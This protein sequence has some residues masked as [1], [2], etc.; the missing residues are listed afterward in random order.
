MKSRQIGVLKIKSKTTNFLMNYY[1]KKRLNLLIVFGTIILTIFPTHIANPDGSGNYPPPPSGNWLINTDTSVSNENLNIYGS[2]VIEGTGS[3]FLDNVLLNLTGDI[4][5]EAGAS[6]K[7]LNSKIIH[8]TPASF[9]IFVTQATNFTMIKSNLSLSRL[10]ISKTDSLMILENNITCM[11]S[12]YGAIYL[13]ECNSSIISKNYIYSSFSRGIYLTSCNHH[14]ISENNVTSL[15][16]TSCLYVRKGSSGEIWNNRIFSS[17]TGIYIWES[18]NWTINGNNITAQGNDG[19]YAEDAA[20]FIIANNNISTQNRY[21]LYF[22]DCYGYTLFTNYIISHTNDGI[23]DIRGYS[24][25]C[26]YNNITAQDLGISLTDSFNANISYN[27]ITASD[28]GIY[29]IKTDYSIIEY[30]NITSEEYAVFLEKSCSNVINNNY[31]NASNAGG[32]GI[33]LIDGCS[34]NIITENKIYAYERGVALYTYS[35]DSSCSSNLIFKNTISAKNYGISLYSYYTDSRSIKDNSFILNSIEAYTGTSFFL[36]KN[37][38]NN[39]FVANNISSKDDG[40][41]CLFSDSN[42]FTGNYIADNFRAMSFDSAS[43]DNLIFCNMF[44]NNTNHASSPNSNSWNNATRGNYWD[45]Y[46]G[47][48]NNGDGIGDTALP[49]EG[50]YYDYFPLMN[51]PY[52][53]IKPITSIQSDHTFNEGESTVEWL[54]WTATDANLGFL[55]FIVNNNHMSTIFQGLWNGSSFGFNLNDFNVG[56]YEITVYVLDIFGNWVVDTCNIGVFPAII[57][58]TTTTL[59][60]GTTFTTTKPSTT[61][62][63]S[64]SPSSGTSS[65]PFYSATPTG[66]SKDGGDVSW[67]I[68]ID[69]GDAGSINFDVN[70]EATLNHDPMYNIDPGDTVTI[71][72]QIEEGTSSVTIRLDDLGTFSD[73]EGTYTIELGAA[74]GTYSIPIPGAAQDIP[75][76]GK[77]GIYLEVELGV[78]VHVVSSGYGKFSSNN[79]ST[80]RTAGTKTFS[81][82]IEDSAKKGDLVVVEAIYGLT[83]TNIAIDLK[84]GGNSVFAIDAEVELDSFP[85][86]DTLS[87]DITVGKAQPVPGFEIFI[88]LPIFL[89]IALLRKRRRNSIL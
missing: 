10:E 12:S 58:T 77:V 9:E 15:S 8:Q 87:I 60:S 57:T 27:N 28:D 75:L 38:Y 82:S 4:T 88:I 1:S 68:P 56:S 30:N 85:T 16:T 31:V 48:D 13:N 66:K 84:A 51:S 25:T 89:G 44:V 63:I 19:I 53:T 55:I 49:I 79:M 73:L 11:G 26:T 20:S 22:I 36:Q 3:L 7:I 33:V 61:S 35:Y 59:T 45:D 76:V 86:S 52:E 41:N 5:V 64:S 46:F 69:L 78:S 42:I 24:I 81:L 14:V 23:H 71:T 18:L 50:S 62:G 37:S 72:S 2:I 17:G 80:H 32:Y 65:T 6:L 74:T 34:N 39:Y 54:N 47:Q 70:T 67:Q 40:F 21:G 29:L 43:T 83:V